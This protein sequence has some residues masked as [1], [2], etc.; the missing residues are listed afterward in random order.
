MLRNGERIVGVDW[1]LL[2]YVARLLSARYPSLE[3]RY[4]TPGL[5]SREHMVKSITIAHK[6]NKK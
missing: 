4:S 1:R 2:D 6:N 5:A 3:Q